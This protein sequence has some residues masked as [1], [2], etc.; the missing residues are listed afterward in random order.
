MRFMTALGVGGEW[1]AGAA[2]VAEVFPSR[3]AADGFGTFAG[4]VGH[5]KYDGLSDYPDP[6]PGRQ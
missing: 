4:P 2:L 5:R 1:A 6:R 3:F